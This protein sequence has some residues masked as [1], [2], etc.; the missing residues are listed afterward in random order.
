[1]IH[2][3]ALRWRRCVAVAVDHDVREAVGLADDAHQLALAAHSRSPGECR[4]CASRAR[5]SEVEA[6]YRLTIW[7]DF[8]P[9]SRIRSDSCPPSARY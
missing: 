1:M 3:A 7:R 5:S 2:Q 9:V 6:A 8:Q 4:R